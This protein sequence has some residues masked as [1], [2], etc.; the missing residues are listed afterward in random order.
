MSSV[1]V[2]AVAR[3]MPVIAQPCKVCPQQFAGNASDRFDG[4]ARLWRDGCA[5]LP[6]RYGGL[7][8]AHLIGERRLAHVVLL[9]VSGDWMHGLLSALLLSL[10]TAPL[11]AV[12]S[13]AV[14]HLP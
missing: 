10:S 13:P 6:K 14:Y 3:H 12:N 8:D 1:K 4:L 2:F 7:R 5:T 9:S 11:M